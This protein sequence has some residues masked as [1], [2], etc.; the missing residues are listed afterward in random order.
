MKKDEKKQLEDQIKQLYSEAEMGVGSAGDFDDPQSLLANQEDLEGLDD[1]EMYDYD[2]DLLDSLDEATDTINNMSDL[3]IGNSDAIVNHP[4]LKQKRTNDASNH[5]DM[6]FLQRMAKKA[7][8]TQLKQMDMGDL[9]PSHFNSFYGG[10]KEVRENIKQAN[11]NQ[12]TMEQFYKSLKTELNIQDKPSEDEE[13]N[14][15]VD[16]KDLN[17]KLEDMMNK[18]EK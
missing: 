2:K 7:L 17:K 18:G 5:A 13:S 10:L 14:N 8:I 16:M 4:Y 15:R 9:T 6:L 11:S 12:N 1:L 3:F